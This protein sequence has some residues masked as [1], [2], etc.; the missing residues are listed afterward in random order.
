MNEFKAAAIQT[1]RYQ[2]GEVRVINLA[3][4]TASEFLGSSE[5]GASLDDYNLDC[6]LT[7]ADLIGAEVIR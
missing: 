7:E 5:Q 2:N 1:V 3:N 6:E 4:M